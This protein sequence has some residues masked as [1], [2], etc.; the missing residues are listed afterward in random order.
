MT[1]YSIQNEYCYS[2]NE[3]DETNE[4]YETRKD[5]D[6][7]D[8]YTATEKMMKEMKNIIEHSK[9]PYLLDGITVST[10]FRLT[11]QN[12][13]IFETEEELDSYL[14][15]DK[16]DTEDILCEANK[17]TTDDF[18]APE[19]MTLED[20]QVLTKKHSEYIKIGPKYSRK[21]FGRMRKNKFERI[22]LAHE[23]KDSMFRQ[24]EVQ[25]SI[26]RKMALQMKQIEEERIRLEK[27]IEEEKARKLKIEEEKKKQEEKK[28]TK[29]VSFLKFLL[30]GKKKEE[31]KEEKK[32]TP[33]VKEQQ[34]ES[35]QFNYTN[36]VKAKKQDRMTEDELLKLYFQ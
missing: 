27:Q 21:C 8:S 16:Y 19:P 2:D 25:D 28:K 31:K 7:D 6:F 18:I 11:K 36:A 4:E 33:V 32:E 1:Y 22:K 20:I 34:K 5:Q 13:N 30:S 12:E 24:M 14:E 29:N 9:N 10:L 17:L 23:F 3:V 15:E 26:K 35:N